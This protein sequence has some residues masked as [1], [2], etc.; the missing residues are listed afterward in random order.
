MLGQILMWL[1][2]ISNVWMMVRWY[3]FTKKDR[4][5]LQQKMDELD[6]VMLDAQ[7]IR[8][9]LDQARA[10]LVLRNN[11]MPSRARMKS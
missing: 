10:E 1:A 5:R 8:S 6:E 4:A 11:P 9:E 3:H 7:R 2:V